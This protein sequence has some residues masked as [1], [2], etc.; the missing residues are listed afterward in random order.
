MKK[1]CGFFLIIYFGLSLPLQAQIPKAGLAQLINQGSDYYNQ[2]NYMAAIEAYK[3]ALGQDSSNPLIH[4]GLAASYLA[5]QN[6]NLAVEHCLSANELNP[7][8]LEA[9]FT[10]AIAYQGLNQTR[11]SLRAY[12]KALGLDL[13]KTS[14]FHQVSLE[15]TQI[16][17]PKQKPVNNSG[18]QVPQDKPNKQNNQFTNL[19]IREADSTE[20]KLRKQ[21]LANPTDDRALYELGLLYLRKNQ[22]AKARTIQ[23]KLMQYNYQFGNDL[24][25]QIEE[26]DEQSEISL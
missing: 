24:L 15:L 8:L 6:Y 2:E 9:Y 14:G 7:A 3:K 18:L 12:R 5:T 19:K 22:L 26:R 21:I 16:P 17:E 25:D 11:Q 10:L 13:K 4:L 1:L 23:Q 20:I